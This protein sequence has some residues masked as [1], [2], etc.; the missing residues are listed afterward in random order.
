MISLAISTGELAGGTLDDGHCFYKNFIYHNKRVEEIN[1]EDFIDNE[2]GLDTVYFNR[3]FK[4]IEFSSEPRTCWDGRNPRTLLSAFIIKTDTQSNLPF[5]SVNFT[6]HPKGV[7]IQYEWTRY[8]VESD[9][10]G[11]VIPRNE[12]NKVISRK[13]MEIWKE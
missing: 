4:A 8:G 3:L 13:L 11:K 1:S 5:R 12:F 9:F 2:I 7:K 10:M 6:F